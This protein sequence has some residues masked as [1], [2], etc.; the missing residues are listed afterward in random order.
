MPISQDTTEEVWTRRGTALITMTDDWVRRRVF[1]AFPLWRTPRRW[2]RS[3]YKACLSRL[4][5]RS[6]VVGAVGAEYS[7]HVWPSARFLFDG[8]GYWNERNFAK[9]RP[10]DRATTCSSSIRHSWYMVSWLREKEW[11]LV[12]NFSKVYRI[13][14]LCIH[15]FFQ[16]SQIVVLCCYS[17][18]TRF[19]RL[20]IDRRLSR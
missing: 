5:S 3:N 8:Q 19:H 7:V 2:L 18:E 10:S 16:A 14:A 6:A 9:Q 13:V 15:T 17:C 1:R 4:F 12:G 20:A 11:Q